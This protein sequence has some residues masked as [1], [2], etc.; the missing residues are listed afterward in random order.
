MPE[1]VE[2]PAT[3][4]LVPI[5]SFDDAKSRLSTVLDAGQRRAYAE[6]MLETVKRWVPITSEAFANHMMAGA[7]LSGQALGVVRRLLSGEP[8]AQEDSGLSK[9][10][11]RELMGTL[12]R[13][14]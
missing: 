13:E 9:R 11:W 12:G 8:V 6:V 2:T 7:H 10:E 4:V 14:S 5:R 1:T 3:V